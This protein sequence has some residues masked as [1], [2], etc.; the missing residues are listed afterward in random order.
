MTVAL[1]A[2]L[3]AAETGW[4]SERA[5]V[6][7]PWR[8]RAGFVL[9]AAVLVAGLWVRPEVLAGRLWA[10]AAGTV[11]LAGAWRR[12][13]GEAGPAVDGL[14]VGLS[15]TAL[16]L[17]AGDSAAVAAGALAG[18]ALRIALGRPQGA[19]QARVERAWAV[20]TWGGLGLAAAVH[21]LLGAPAP[22]HPSPAWAI[23]GL[24][25]WDWRQ[26]AARATSSRAP[27]GPPPPV[28]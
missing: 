7:R 13:Q 3:A 11:L 15:L 4:E 22:T 2:L 9:L 17:A 6:D 10:L 20:A 21:A 18:F 19:P 25:V 26:A 27:T 5:L 16:L 28:P 8:E 23:P 14:D 1:W 24:I 12:M